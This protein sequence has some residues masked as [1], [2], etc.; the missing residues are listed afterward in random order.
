MS[1]VVQASRPTVAGAIGLAEHDPSAALPLIEQ[2]LFSL[3]RLGA[4]R[5]VGAALFTLAKIKVKQGDV[6]HARAAFEEILSMPGVVADRLPV[7]L[8]LAGLAWVADADGAIASE[9]TPGS[10]RP[11]GNASSTLPHVT[12]G[13]SS[14]SLFARK[15]PAKWQFLLPAS[16]AHR[17]EGGSWFLARC[18]M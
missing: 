16:A 11:G 12:L 6:V 9:T 18:H 14:N 3:R 10:I 4:D 5:H 13:Y 1:H 2:A 8:A 15:V 17:R 7:T